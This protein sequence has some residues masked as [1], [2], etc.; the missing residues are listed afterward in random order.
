[1]NGRIIHELS[2]WPKFRWEEGRLAAPLSAARHLQGR[3]V[4]KME[5]LGFR[6]REEA[7]LRTLTRG[8]AEEQRD[9]RREARR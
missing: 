8:R 3:Q 1:V 5:A 9:R 4:G 2:D 6:L 7:V